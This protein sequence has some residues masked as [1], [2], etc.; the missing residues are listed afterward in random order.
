MSVIF[1]GKDPEEPIRHTALGRKIEAVEI[2][3][4]VLNLLSDK[5][6]V[7]NGTVITINGGHK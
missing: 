4:V 6:N 5:M 2:A 1:E 3:D 7:V